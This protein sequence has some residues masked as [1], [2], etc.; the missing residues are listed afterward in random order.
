[1]AWESQAACDAWRNLSYSALKDYADLTVSRQKVFE[2]EMTVGV[3]QE[4]TEFWGSLL[5]PAMNSWR[6][7]EGVVLQAII[8]IFAIKGFLA[9][10]QRMG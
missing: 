5:I 6:L 9:W 8:I 4:H 2:G 10:N 3:F 1:M 7:G